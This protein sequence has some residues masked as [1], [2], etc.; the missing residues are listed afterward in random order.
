MKPNRSRDNR[1]SSPMNFGKTDDQGEKDRLS[2]KDPDF[3]EKL[4]KKAGFKLE[5]NTGKYLL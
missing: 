4:A 2:S 1:F 3:L 5:I